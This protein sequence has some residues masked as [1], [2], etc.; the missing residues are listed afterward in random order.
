[1]KI[2]F[3]I[4]LLLCICFMCAVLSTY[5]EEGEDKG[6]EPIGKWYEWKI[7]TELPSEQREIIDYF[8]KVGEIDSEIHAIEWGT[9]SPKPTPEQGLEIIDECIV[10][11]Q[12]LKVP[13]ICQKHYDATLQYTNVAIKYQEARKKYNGWDNELGRISTEG[14]TYEA[15]KFSEFWR[16]LNEAGFMDDFEEE[17]I[18]LGLMTMEEVEKHYGFFK[19]YKKGEPVAC[20]KCKQPMRRVKIL[21]ETDSGY[22]DA[23]TDRPNEYLFGSK[24]FQGCPEYGYMCDKCP[25]WYE[26]YS[27][28]NQDAIIM[29]NWCWGVHE[30]VHKKK[31]KRIE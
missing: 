14:M 30:L 3:R 1:M 31:A 27:G 28:S 17:W 20:P 19:E 23:I 18:H 29:R 10:E 8:Q 21:Y 6:W 25:E 4:I 7:K 24:R 9:K 15:T 16:V 11:Y 12:S 13:E 5:A 2:S 22:K 26:E